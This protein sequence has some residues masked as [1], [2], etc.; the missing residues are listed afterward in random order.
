MLDRRSDRHR[1]SATGGP[2]KG[3]FRIDL[4]QGQVWWSPGMWLLHGLRPRPAGEPAPGLRAMIR[5]R[6]PQDRPAMVRAWRQLRDTGLP[7]CFDDRILGL[8]GVI[9]PVMIIAAVTT[10]GGGLIVEG[11]VQPQS[12]PCT[13]SW[14]SGHPEPHRGSGRTS[15]ASGS[16]SGGPER[17]DRISVGSARDVRG[18]QRSGHFCAAPLPR[19]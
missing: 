14:P 4:G 16:G 1:R 3:A 10:A 12:L 19:D 17:S 5:Y 7:V 2:V 15:A 9:R 6:R 8:D 11:V 18:Q 13:N